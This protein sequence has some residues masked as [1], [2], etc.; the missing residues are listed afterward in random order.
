MTGAVVSKSYKD[1]YSEEGIYNDLS[2]GGPVVSRGLRHAVALEQNVLGK[3]KNP[4]VLVLG[5]GNGYEVAYL[6]KYDCVSLEHYIPDV[7]VVQERSVKGSADA[8]PFKDKTFD[9]TFCCETLE[10]IPQE[11]C[12]K[13]LSEVKRVSSLYY[14]TIATRGDPPFNTH[15]NIK[16]GED[17]IKTFREVFDG[18][19]H[20]QVNPNLNIRIGDRLSRLIYPDGVLIYGNC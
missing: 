8:M 1:P 3:F 19:L 11:I 6:S 9:V 18:V 12:E 4:K 13:I 20:A 14:F 10:H 7:K 5:A 16:N 15:I 17:W 2:Y